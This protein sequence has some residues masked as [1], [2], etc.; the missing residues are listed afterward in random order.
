MARCVLEMNPTGCGSV[1]TEI[2]NGFGG[3][4]DYQQYVEDRSLS[5]TLVDL[6]AVVLQR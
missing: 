2:P 5:S 6:R 3:P 1:S 4:A